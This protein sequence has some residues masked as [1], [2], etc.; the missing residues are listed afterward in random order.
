MTGNFPKSLMRAD[1]S[2]HTDAGA[3]TVIHDVTRQPSGPAN[4][5]TP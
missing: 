2:T 3:V 1:G 4:P 5:E